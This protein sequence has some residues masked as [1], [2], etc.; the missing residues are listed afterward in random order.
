MRIN[1]QKRRQNVLRFAALIAN[2]G[3]LAAGVVLPANANLF[4]SSSDVLAAA[5]PLVQVKGAARSAI[6]AAGAVR[7]AGY[8][9]R[10]QTVLKAPGAPGVVTLYVEGNFGKPIKIAQ[11]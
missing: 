10:N 7:P 8:A 5:T 2:P 9:E 6:G 3:N 4:V 11:G 1:E